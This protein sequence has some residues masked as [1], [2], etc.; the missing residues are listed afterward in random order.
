MVSLK[1][2]N[3]TAVRDCLPDLL[4]FPNFA[5]AQVKSL[6]V[7]SLYKADLNAIMDAVSPLPPPQG[8]LLAG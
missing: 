3:Q 5:V 7:T 1:A 8:S 4:P 6:S 2:G